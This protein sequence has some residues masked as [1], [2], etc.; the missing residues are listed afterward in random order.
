MINAT[1]IFVKYGDRVLLDHVNFVIT[2]KD[3]VGL[4][5]RNGAGK[6]TILKIISRMMSP[7]EGSITLPSHATIGFLHQDMVLPKGKTVIEEAM[8][9]FDRVKELEQR[10]EEINHEL[11]YRTDY[12]SDSYNDILIELSEATEL[13]QV[14]GGMT[15]QAEA[16]KILSGLGFK[17][18]DM[19]RL[20]DEFSGGW[21]MRIE[22]TKMLLQRPSYLLLD[23]PTNHLDIESILWLEQFLQ[24][25]EGAVITI[26][27]DKTFLDNVTKRTIEI[28]IG[29]LYDYKANYSKFKIL[30][31]E[32]R[33]KQESAFKNQQK[34]IENTEKLIEKF[35][36][37]ANKAKMAQSLIKQLDKLDRIDL[38][39]TANS[40]MKIRFIPAPRSGEIVIDVKNMVK[41]Y[42]DLTV[43]NGVDFQL[44][45]GQRIAFVGQNGQGKTTLSKI[46]AGVE[47]HTSGN[48]E[49]GHNVNI[50]YYAQNQA[51]AFH[52]S[53]T[54]LET[55][56]SGAPPELRVRVRSILG[57]FMFSGDDVEKKV[58]VLSGGERARLAMA[59]LLLHPFN[60]L[61]LD[62]PTNHLDIQSKEVLKE[63][64]MQYDGALI[65]VSHDRD[66]LEGL[67]DRTLEFRDQ[68]LYNY[69]GDVQAFL[70]KRQL[71]NMREVELREKKQ[72]QVAAKTA[73]AIIVAKA[74]ARELSFEER[75]ELQK[76]KKK[77]E[78]NVQNLE[79]K[80]EKLED[81]VAKW[82][83]KMD[84][85]SFYVQ[86]DSDA[87]IE[88]YN[89]AKVDLE[90]VMQEWEE[91]QMELEAFMESYVE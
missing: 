76:D 28:E 29:K 14:L 59:S 61:I 37:K 27:H 6:S 84:D 12:E 85:P 43:L 5:G 31:K 18:T 74:P 39:A 81:D 26:S 36:A 42:G 91:A 77:F 88:K 57:S 65:V 35:R 38:D 20:T 49:I 33:E 56:E 70:E 58:S 44:E 64:L 25:Y 11:T 55:L 66:F 30:Q 78:R 79:R 75:K 87:Q 60:L 82:E 7:H 52:K 24:G 72:V 51:E 62:E 63:A 47:G 23:E 54:V 1:N 2:E 16:E 90:T 53:E 71:D 4:V 22:L 89:R 21:Q 67:T 41:S 9:A 80:I 17:P 68:Q 46:I 13:F 32:R 3:R 73:E 15:M 48:V 34:H 83:A 10:I 86:S 69:I 50:G 40:T 19:N 45:R 8:T